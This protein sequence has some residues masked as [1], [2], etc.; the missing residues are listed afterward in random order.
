MSIEWEYKVVEAGPEESLM[1][2]ANVT[3]TFDSG[4]F[5]KLRNS[6]TESLNILGKEGWGLCGCSPHNY[7]FKRPIT[8]NGDL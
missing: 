5:A 4:E 2:K 8:D 7:I 3:G 1:Y 6:I